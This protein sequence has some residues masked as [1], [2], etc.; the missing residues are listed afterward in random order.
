VLSV[1][2][3]FGFLKLKNLIPPVSNF[4]EIMPNFHSAKSA[5]IIDS[6]VLCEIVFTGML[7]NINK[8]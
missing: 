6:C 4:A 8:Q 7:V 3:D 5:E 1:V 2:N